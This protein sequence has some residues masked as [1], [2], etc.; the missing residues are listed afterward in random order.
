MSTAPSQKQLPFHLQF[1][2]GA[3]AGICEITTM[4]P[5]D[6]VKTRFQQQTTAGASATSQ[7]YTGIMNCFRRII[8]EEGASRLYRGI[9][10]P[11]MVEAP[12]RA[13]KFATQ[14]EYTK[15][16]QRTLSTYPGDHTQLIS[17]ISGVLTGIT[18]A[19]IVSSFEL[20]KIRM[21]DR[22]NIS[23]YSSTADCAKKIWKQE[24]PLT[25]LRGIEA[26]CWRNGSWNGAYFSVIHSI[27]TH[28]PPISVGGNEAGSGDGVRNFIAGTLGGIAATT[29]NTPFDVVKTRIQSRLPG[30]DK[31][32]P[33]RFAW[34]GVAHI[35][36]IE[37]VRGLYRGYLA[38]VLRLG[39][40][41]GIL[42]VV[43]DKVSSMLQKYA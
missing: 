3:V 30:S 42:L 8:S 33:Y 37:G 9:L 22:S 7:P 41:G 17:L 2:A 5:L 27:K 31:V 26:A 10:A 4:Y 15:L 1:A 36:R 19:W 16:A 20:V 13:M 6:V 35:V 43:F 25:F 18:E 28:L 23:L 14:K 39:P 38:K 24:G 40:G 32:A 21:Q 11:I 29:V 12:K 34:P